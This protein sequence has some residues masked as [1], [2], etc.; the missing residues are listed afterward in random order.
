MNSRHA[1]ETLQCNEQESEEMMDVHLQQCL[2]D[3][4]DAY[5]VVIQMQFKPVGKDQ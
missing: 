5:L 3:R 1:T 2:H 4:S